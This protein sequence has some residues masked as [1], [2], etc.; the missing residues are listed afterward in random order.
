ME[1]AAELMNTMPVSMCWATRSP[2]PLRQYDVRHLPR[3]D[4]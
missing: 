2:R 4:Q 1:T 3:K